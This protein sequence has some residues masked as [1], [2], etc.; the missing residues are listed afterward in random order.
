MAARRRGIGEGTIRERSD[1]RWEA[2]VTVGYEAG[3]RVR[4]SFYGRTRAEVAGRMTVAIKDLAHGQA[5][6]PERETVGSYLRSWLQDVKPSIRTS[7]WLRYEQIVAKHLVPELGTVR[8]SRLTPQAVNGALVRRAAAGSAPKTVAHIRGTLRSAL[9]D[10]IEARLITYNP[11]SYSRP[12]RLA[13]HDV[14]PMAPVEA[15]AILAAFQGTELEALVATAVYTGA[16]QG[17]LL[18]L[19]WADVDLELGKVQIGRSLQRASHSLAELKTPVLAELKTAKSRRILPLP[20]PARDLLVRH[21]ARQREERSRLGLAWAAGGIRDLVFCDRVGDPLN[22]TNV[23]KHFKTG[24][25]RA[26]LA[27]RR[28]HDLRHGAATLLLASGVDLKTVS[29]MLGHSQIATTANI[30]TG[31]LDSLKKDAADR[32]VDILSL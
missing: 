16:R 20:A 24:L 28:W 26:G 30:Y 18:G 17:E 4:R 31:V 27:P 25:R 2:R 7:T 19:R 14:T 29:T 6:S 1:G 3:K 11:A 23:T 32:L 22:G 8:L 5:P 13:Q 21:R 9:N 10:A 15:R 12:P